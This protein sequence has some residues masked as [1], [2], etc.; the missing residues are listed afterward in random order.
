MALRFELKFESCRPAK[1]ADLG[2]CGFKSHPGRPED[3][4]LNKKEKYKLYHF[5]I[6]NIK[7]NSVALERGA[8]QTPLSSEQ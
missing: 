4:N 2:P 5:Y 1:L 8:I 6:I 3:L 7:D